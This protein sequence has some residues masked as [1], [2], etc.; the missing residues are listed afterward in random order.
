MCE[1]CLALSSSRPA[2]LRR[3]SRPLSS[4]LCWTF[5]QC[6]FCSPWFSTTRM[7]EEA[8]S[9]LSFSDLERRWS[10]KGIVR[11]VEIEFSLDHLKGWRHGQEES[12]GIVGGCAGRGRSSANLRCFRRLAQRHHGLD[13]RKE[14]N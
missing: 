4:T 2:C 5:C 8:H 13:S 1:T 12:G 3:P 6:S 7:L 10:F 14:T 11:S 9:V